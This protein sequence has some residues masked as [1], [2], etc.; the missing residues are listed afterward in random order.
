MELKILGVG[1][2]DNVGLPFNSYMFDGHV[3][4]DTPPDILQS[5]RRESI[6]LESI[7]AVVL[8]HFHGDHCFGLPFLLFNIYA[9]RGARKTA[10]PKLVVPA[11]GKETVKKLL[12]IAISPDHPYVAW[13][14]NE[15]EIVEVDEASV[16]LIDSPDPIELRFRHAEHSVTTY[17]I[18]AKRPGEK[19]PRIIA[20]ADTRWS[21]WIGE[22]F[23][24]GAGIYLCDANGSGR[25]GVHMSA[26]ELEEYV[27]PGL[28]SGTRLLAT[29]LSDEP[30][31]GGA[32]EYAVSGKAYRA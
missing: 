5:L 16:V 2:F 9:R 8:T 20:T 30:P 19:K 23:A 25:G 10:L 17:S 11:P 15:M 3:L 24:M 14:M 22:L 7:D 13:A 6:S 21:P 28:E 4:V 29:H 31:A 32:I 1:G 27:L 26:L 12:E 18:I